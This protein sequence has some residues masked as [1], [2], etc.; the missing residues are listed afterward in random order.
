[1]TGRWSFWRPIDWL[2]RRLADNMGA[3]NQLRLGIVCCLLTIPLYV[4]C[5]WSG[6]PPLIYLMSAVAL[7]LTGVGIVVSAQVLLKQEQ[8][9]DDDAPVKPGWPPPSP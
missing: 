6:E 8:Q 2:A 3:E 9:D 1:V 4:Y 7:T 5:G